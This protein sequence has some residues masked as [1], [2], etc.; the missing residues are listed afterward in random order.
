MKQTFGRQYQ[1]TKN[2][3]HKMKGYFCDS[4]PEQIKCPRCR[5]GTLAGLIR[6]LD[7]KGKSSRGR[8]KRVG[9]KAKTPEFA[10]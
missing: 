4:Q 5:D 9:S 10:A 3:R 8:K 2:P 6:I 7:V 1:C